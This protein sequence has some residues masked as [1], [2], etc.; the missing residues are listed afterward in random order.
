MIYFT[1]YTRVPTCNETLPR[2]ATARDRSSLF[3][4]TFQKLPEAKPWLPPTPQPPRPPRPWLRLC[5][6]RAA[7]WIWSTSSTGPASSASIRTRPTTSPMSSSTCLAAFSRPSPNLFD[8]YSIPWILE[9]FS[10]RRDFG[11]LVRL[12]VFC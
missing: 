9:I 4:S 1:C 11:R 8:P 5:R 7:R 3:V 2:Y 12:L 6:C 10:L